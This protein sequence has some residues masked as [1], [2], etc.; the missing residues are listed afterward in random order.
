MAIVQLANWSIKHLGG[1]KGPGVRQQG[2]GGAE[3]S[4]V[5]PLHRTDELSSDRKRRARSVAAAR[6]PRAWGHKKGV[7]RG[8]R[9]LIG[10]LPP[11]SIPQ[12]QEE[13]AD[14]Q[15]RL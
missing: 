2:G 14:K 9:S 12:Q 10:M 15:T 11:G 4:P 6:L 3:D 1:L 13:R 7:R 8:A 5:R